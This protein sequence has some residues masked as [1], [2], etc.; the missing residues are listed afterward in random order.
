[1]SSYEEFYFITNLK[2][3]RQMNENVL[4]FDNNKTRRFSCQN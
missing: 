1:M 2:F 4:I 3:H